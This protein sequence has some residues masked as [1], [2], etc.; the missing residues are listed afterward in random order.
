MSLFN[1]LVQELD[2]EWA[3]IDGCIVKAHQHRAGAA[4]QENQ[5]IGKFRGANTTN[6]SR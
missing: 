4:S 3:F 1:A 5:A 2:L 6:I